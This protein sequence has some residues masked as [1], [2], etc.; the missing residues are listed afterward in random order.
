MKKESSDNNLRKIFNYIKSK[1]RLANFLFDKVKLRQD[2]RFLGGHLFKQP[3]NK[4]G[5]GCNICFH[6]KDRYLL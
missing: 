2:F 4:P 6:T 5:G 3:E 1:Q